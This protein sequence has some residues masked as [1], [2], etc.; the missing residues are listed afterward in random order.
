[1]QQTKGQALEVRLSAYI[2]GEIGEAERTE[3]EALLGR[4][5]DA[6]AL[7]ERLK[8]GSS[9]GDTAFEDFL[10]DP[11]PLALV[12][13]IKQGPG[14]NPKTERVTTTT[15]TV[16]NVRI[17]PRVLAASVALMLLGGAAGFIVGTANNVAEP[18]KI[19]AARGWLD[20]IADYHRIYSRQKE[21][22]VEA[23]ASEG[24]KIETWLASSVG[25]PFKIPQLGG[26]GLTFEGARLLV[27]NGKPVAQLVY[28]STEGEI[29]AICFL[30]DTTGPQS[31]E[32]DESIRDDL[33]MVSWQR[34]GASFVL[35]GPSAHVGMQDIAETVAAAI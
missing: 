4:D 3:L 20:E 13:Q 1:M 2:D 35:V 25:V 12:R 14:V 23:P 17:W 32:F 8:A 28:R 31:G 27:A 34:G 21:H 30:K 6:K 7:F 9:F 10:H 33:G 24:P 5:E 11:V 29:F 22:L 15:A 26:K 16:R 19:A 18:T